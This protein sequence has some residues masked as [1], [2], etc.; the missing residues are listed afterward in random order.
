MVGILKVNCTYQVSSKSDLYLQR[1]VVNYPATDHKNHVLQG[2]LFR[3]WV[4]L[5]WL[6]VNYPVV[7]TQAMNYRASVRAGWFND[8]TV[9]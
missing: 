8:N 9:E 1:L 2:I 4:V 6:V 3:F 5:Q 7:H